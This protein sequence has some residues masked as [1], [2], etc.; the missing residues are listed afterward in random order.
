MLKRTAVRFPSPARRKMRPVAVTSLRKPRGQ[1][2]LQVLPINQST[3]TSLSADD[4]P[5]DVNNSVGP[6][7]VDYILGISK[8]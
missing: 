6:Y 8:H 7:T 3:I 4:V 1:K 2:V 5:F